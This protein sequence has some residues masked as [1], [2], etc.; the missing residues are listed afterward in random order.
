M[1]RVGFV[2]VYAEAVW[3]LGRHD[4]ALGV[5]RVGAAQSDRQGEHLWD[6]E[7][8]RLRG[9]ILLDQDEGRTEEPERLFHEA[10]EIARRQEAK[11]WELR[12]AT[13]LARLWQRQGKQAEARDVLQPVYG[14][15]TEGFG[16]RDLK[17]AKALLDELV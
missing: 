12:S 16:T 7:L 5:L 1:V 13:S 8:A 15:F 14:W 3:T 9:E 2:A 4:E 10:L 17:D 6:A 11:G